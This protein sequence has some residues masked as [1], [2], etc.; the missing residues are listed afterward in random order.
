MVAQGSTQYL[1]QTTCEYQ[2]DARPFLLHV[3][4]GSSTANQQERVDRKAMRH[5]IDSHGTCWPETG[6]QSKAPYTPAH[7]AVFNTCLPGDILEPYNP[8]I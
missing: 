4:S 2:Q 1:A 6:L 7:L 5:K 3:I 8:C